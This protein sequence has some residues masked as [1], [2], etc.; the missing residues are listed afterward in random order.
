VIYENFPKT[1][2]EFQTRFDTEEKCADYL[3][4]AR[5]PSGFVCPHCGHEGG[6]RRPGREEYVCGSRECRKETSL[7]SGTVLHNSPKAVRVWL[8]AMFLMTTNKQSVS[9]LRLQQLMGFG[10]YRTALRWLRELRRAMSHV[11]ENQ[12]LGSEVEIDETYIGRRYSKKQPKL[13]KTEVR[14]AGAVERLATGCGRVR[15]R[16]LIGADQQGSIKK[17]VRE[18][19]QPGSLIHS[20]ALAAYEAMAAESYLVDAR[21]SKGKAG[22]D[23]LRLEDGTPK[24]LVH[25]PRIH[26]VFSL[27]KRVLLGAH[28]GAASARHLQLYLDEYSF[29]FNRRND[30]RPLAITQRLSDAAVKVKAVPYWRSSGRSSPTTPSKPRNTIWADYGRQFSEVTSG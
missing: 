12:V 16:L 9:A 28:Q 18:I 22:R 21:P 26:R 24:V 7:R 20:D 8:W 1:E 23:V 14:I 25:L 5:W 3:S 15:L 10:C 11:V 27:L 2:F 6:R 30:D 19:V 4:S 17:F 13:P 29:R